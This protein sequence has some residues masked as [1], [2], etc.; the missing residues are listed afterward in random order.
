MTVVLTEVRSVPARPVG[1][2]STAACGGERETSEWQR[3]KKSRTSVS[4]KI[5]FGHRNRTAPYGTGAHVGA[6]LRGL[7]GVQT[8]S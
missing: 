7:T 6:P 8:G 3:S 2:E 4:P 5:F 1:S